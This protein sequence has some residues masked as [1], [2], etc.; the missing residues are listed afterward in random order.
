MSRT[1]PNPATLEE[2][3][4]LLLQYTDELNQFDQQVEN[5]NTQ[6]AENAQTIEQ[7]RTLNQ[8]LYLRL[9]QA[10]QEEPKDEP[11]EKETLEDF[12][13]NNL[14]GLIP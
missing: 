3:R 2:A 12:A 9:P 6:N 1:A 11:E 7:L 13:R 5:L 4:N 8:Q 14:K 10:Q